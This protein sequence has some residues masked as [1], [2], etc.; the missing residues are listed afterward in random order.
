M[1]SL[2]EALQ[3]FINEKN[4]QIQLAAEDKKELLVRFL[5]SIRDYEHEAGKSIYSDDRESIEIVEIFLEK[6]E[7]I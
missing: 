1:E 6:H 5:D 2:Q 4:R 7:T 3:D